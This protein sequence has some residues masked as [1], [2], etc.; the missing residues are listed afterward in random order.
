LLPRRFHFD[1]KTATEDLS[2]PVTF[3]DVYQEFNEKIA[4]KYKIMTFKSMKVTRMYA[5]D[6]PD[7]PAESEYLEVRY[8][9]DLPV[10][11]MDLFGETFSHV[12]GTN[13]SAL[14]TFL[15]D[16]K[17]KGP[18]WL[19]ISGAQ[20]SSP[21][22]SWCRLEAFV[23]K[24]DLVKLSDSIKPSPPPPLVV[25]TVSFRTAPHP[26][27][28]QNEIIAVAC[29]VHRL[30]PL[31]RAAPKPPFESHFCIVAPP[32][33]CV[34]PFDFR[35]HILPSAGKPGAIQVPM[36]IEPVSTER[37]LIGLFLARVHKIDPDVI[38]GHD[39]VGYD[40]DVLM[41]RI[42]INKVPHW[43][44]L[45]R[46]RRATV[47]KYGARSGAAAPAAG[48]LVLDTMISARELI[49]CRSYDLTEL[50]SHVLKEN[51]QVYDADEVHSAFN[52]TNDLLHL[53]ESSL[54]DATYSLRIA[55]DLSALPLAAQIT[56]ICGNVMSRTL[57]G[58]RSERN[59]Y[60]LLHAF[61]ER[62]FIV[63][64]KIYGKA[65]LAAAAAALQVEDHED[66]EERD[67]AGSKKN[68]KSLRRKPAYTG[69]LVLEPKRGFYDKY[70]LL[71]DF[72]SLYPSIIQE[73][74][75]CFTTVSNSNQ[76]SKVSTGDEEEYDES[77]VPVSGLEPGVLPTEIRRLVES[78]RHVRQLMKSPAVTSDQLAQYDIRQRALKLTA[79]SLYGCLGFTHSRFYARRL[80][81]LVT[82]KGRE[83]LLKT[84]DLVQAMNLDVIYG[85]TD[86]LMIATGSLDID[87]VYRLGNRI[88]SE[89]NKLY[90]HLEI[91][92]D[93]VFRSM[94]LLK[95]KKYAALAVQKVG[96]SL[97]T[98]QEMKGLDM[99][100]RDWCTL[101]KDAG[102]FV[103]SQ[104]LSGESR[105]V[106]LET[107][108]ARLMEIGNAVRAGEIPLASF[109][110]TKQLAKN[111]E[112]YP[113]R[114]SLPHVQVAMRLNSS[115]VTNGRRLRAGDAVVYVVCEDGS[116]LPATQRAYHP[117]LEVSKRPNELKID[118]K[119]YLEQQVHP[120]VARL[121]DPIEGTDAARIAEC[122]GLDV[123]NFR[124]A[125]RHEDDDD[126][127]LLAAAEES[128]AA[129]YRDCERF[130]FLCR[131]CSALITV[132]S[133]IKPGEKAKLVLEKCPSC[134]L[135]PLG[136]VNYIRN[137]LAMAMRRHIHQYYE[138]WHICE[139]TAC[140]ART[141]RIPLTLNLGEPVCTV[142]RHGILRPEFSDRSLYLQLGFFRHVF[143]VEKA[144]ASGDIQRIDPL[145]RDG[146]LRLKIDVDHVLKNSGY[147]HVNLSR[148]FEGMF[149]VISR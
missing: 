4:E 74:N 77:L 15:L 26:R 108:H 101:A 107:I 57:A 13:T 65:G 10:L 24:P 109:Q 71:V 42:N 6:K 104:I 25:M 35:D 106:V 90:R 100:R 46:L 142:C 82:G 76:S 30:F 72:N 128:E 98:T 5:F 19:D 147:C 44:K 133:V 7:V 143:D 146:M 114:K 50:A 63:P 21:P 110:I 58:G 91:D 27:T 9:A 116:N 136:D 69:G 130:S 66:D 29:L 84:K 87:E 117:D 20:V 149:P 144:V 126:E 131:G 118:A 67:A 53:I 85:D 2:R 137:R 62:N 102:T 115:S 34:L 140:A 61:A 52:S 54:K 127:A 120:V 111:P 49:R 45:G 141:R 64:D 139:D 41:H 93:G 36:T 70:I 75:I 121:C 83:I 80:A 16:R 43:S 135:C 73:Y 33:N 97:V 148:L 51:R 39:I 48:R 60:L 122:L 138:G 145:M 78:R 99:V 56:N 22:I 119:Y 132:E 95:K 1:V 79:N 88:K 55:C 32:T 92:I 18:S 134:D 14:E 113:D 68:S 40:F 59:E 17:I 103:V 38:V 89:V 81:A 129:K 3:I 124:Q 23:T 96:E 8:S 47:P 37:G 112:D 86:S 123:G 125:T 31:D 12:F 28:H 105:E 94:L 11:P